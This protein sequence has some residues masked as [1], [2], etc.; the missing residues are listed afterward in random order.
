[1]W[2][3][4]NGFYKLI[5]SLAVLKYNR[6]FLL[7]SMPNVTTNFKMALNQKATMDFF[8]LKK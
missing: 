1:M 3:T 4:P 6:I 5:S 2:L 7:N 8:F